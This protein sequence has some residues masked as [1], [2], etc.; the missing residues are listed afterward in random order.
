MEEA[1]YLE[2]FMADSS[3]NICILIDSVGGT[4]MKA[5]YLYTC[6][7]QGVDVGLEKKGLRNNNLVKSKYVSVV[8]DQFAITE[9]QLKDILPDPVF[10]VDCRRGEF[11]Y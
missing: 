10:E 1:T 8:N 4:R 7:I 9:I 6:G 3:T 5:H 2:S 11:G